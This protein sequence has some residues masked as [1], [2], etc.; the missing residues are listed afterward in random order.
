MADKFKAALDLQTL[1]NTAGS[2]LTQ[3]VEL[4]ESFVGGDAG[5]DCGPMSR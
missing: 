4:N 5:A 1:D 3:N 2:A